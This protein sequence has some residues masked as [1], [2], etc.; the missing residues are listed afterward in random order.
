MTDDGFAVYTAGSSGPV[1]M[2]LHG[3]GLNAMSWA[4]AASKMKSK[5]RIIT[6]DCR[7]HGDTTLDASD[8]SHTVLINDVKSILT[9]QLGEDHPPV[10]LIGHSMG[11]AIAIRS[12]L[13]L[14]GKVAAL[15]VL[16]VVEGT[17]IAA[18]PKMISILHSRPN[19]F[20]SLESA[21]GWALSSGNVRNKE[22]ACVSVPPQLVEKDGEYYWRTDLEKTAPFWKGWFENMSELFL[23][24]PAPKLLVLADTNRLDKPLTIAQMMGKFQMSIVPGVGHCIQEDDPQKTADFI[25]NFLERFRIK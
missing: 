16:D 11:G 17:A 9:Q 20:D 25:V 18:L 14:K 8:M 3:A 1:C 5:Y 13:E 21:I 19:K 12:A 22:S 15:I 23:S 10:V 4:V 24:V 2:L 7:G 6:Y